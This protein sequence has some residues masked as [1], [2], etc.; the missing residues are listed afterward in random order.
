ML[1]FPDPKLP[2]TVVT[3]ASGTAAGGVLMQDQGDNPRPIAFMSRAVKPTEQQYSAYERELAAIAYCFIQWR[4]YLEGCLGGV[5]VITNHQP[6]T[7]L[8]EQQVLSR[9]QSRWLRH[10]QFQSIQPKMQYQPGKANIV[11]D[12]LSR[13]RASVKSEESAQQEQRSDQD[14]EAQCDQAFTIT[15][16]VRLDESELS[17][18]RDAQQ[19]A[20]VLKTLCELPE[21]ELQ[22][23]NFEISPQGILVR[24][25][26]DQQRPVVPK[27]M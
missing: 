18:F 25:E 8:M 5:T 9:L 7:H 2:Y 27:E 15:S 23:R 3:D 12:A 1:I 4:H 16:S 11:A 6:L 26:D 20:P 22:R 21:M 13:S 14:V 10:G 17:A 24:V 19:A